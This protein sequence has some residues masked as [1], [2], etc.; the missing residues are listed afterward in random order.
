MSLSLIVILT[1]PPLPKKK[2]HKSRS[3]LCLRG[4]IVGDGWNLNQTSHEASNKAS[5]HPGVR[6]TVPFGFNSFSI[7]SLG[8]A[9]RHYSEALCKGP[10]VCWIPVLPLFEEGEKEVWRIQVSKCPGTLI[11]RGL[12][13]K[14]A[15]SGFY[16]PGGGKRFQGSWG[17]SGTES[18][19]PTS[20]CLGMWMCLLPAL[21]YHY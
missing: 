1:S 20:R 7:V 10:G 2:C 21:R 14:I 13:F 6:H 16:R 18:W 12:A 15:F 3:D 4:E 11:S 5:L 19:T 17:S 9:C 8:L